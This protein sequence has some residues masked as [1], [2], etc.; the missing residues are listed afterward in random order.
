V[1]SKEHIEQFDRAYFIG[2]GGIGMSALARYFNSLGWPVAGYDKT[3]SPLTAKL[4]EEGIDIH[5]EDFGPSIPEGF[6][7]TDKTLVVYTPAIPRNFGEL[8]HVQH[9]GFV[10]KKRAEVLGM[11]TQNTKGLAVAGTHGKTTTS[12]ML[13]HILDVSDEKCNA[14]LGGISSNF[15]SNFVQG[16]SD[17]TVVEADEFDRSF[18]HLTPLASIITSTDADHLDIYGNSDTFLEGFREYAGQIQ[19]KGLMVRH[20]DVDLNHGNSETYAL[21]READYSGWNP[22]VEDGFF[23]IDVKTPESE[24]KSVRLG[25]PGVHNAE[26]AIAC[27]ALAEFVGLDEQTIRK[28][29]ESFKGVKRRFEYHIRE[30]NL[31]YIDDYAHHPTE[32]KALID[33]VELLYAGKR[34]T[35]IFQPH[36]FTRTRDFFDGFAEQL[37]RLDELVLMPIYPAREEP[38]SGITSDALLDRVTALNRELVPADEIVSHIER[39]RDVN[40][41]KN[42]ISTLLDAQNGGQVILTI[43]AGDIDRIVEPLKNALIS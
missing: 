7:N 36:L 8:L 31:V 4:E 6:R 42:S 34:I 21:S 14:F 28:G 29:L 2:V 17:W 26:N 39:S 12:T 41:E 25:L 27:I 38:I 30:E 18:L 43:G 37:S 20:L 40:S 19:S 10:V 24:W 22:R 1:I 16:N 32:I 3:P 33:S 5:Y 15:Q 9:A 35:G 11:I 13:A 23:T